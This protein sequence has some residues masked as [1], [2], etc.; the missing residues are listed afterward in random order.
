MV[1]TMAAVPAQA[2]VTRNDQ[3]YL[4][5]LRINEAHRI[6][7][8]G[9]VVVGI[10]DT[11]VNGDQPD[12]VG[13]VL[14]GADAASGFISAAQRDQNGHGTAVATIVAGH[15]HG[16]GGQEGILG[17]SPSAHIL[18]IRADDTRDY[19]AAEA[20]GVSWAADHGAKVICVAFIGNNTAE[21][22]TAVAKARAADALIIA[23]TGNRDSGHNEIGYPA[24]LDGVI[25]VG[26]TTRA[27]ILAGFS[28][29]GQATALT[30]PGTEISTP[31]LGDGYETSEGTSF[32]T[33]IV[34]G[35]AALVRAK[36][37]NLSAAEVAHR[38]E[39]TAD[40]EGPPGRD[41]QYGYGIVN[42]LKALTA[43]VPPLGASPSSTTNNQ[44]A[45]QHDR[46]LIVGTVL[47]AL[48]ALVG[49]VIIVI[50]ALRWRRGQPG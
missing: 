6:V 46:K 33:A 30:A 14:P 44:S 4:N 48:S 25:A 26:A 16:V 29:T 1:A 13:S 21:W 15:G 3:W 12:L 20:N 37:P 18:P 35:V 23:G 34:A 7:T 47:L 28:L 49:A 38:L 2:D 41:D 22:A 9:D 43:D 50:A 24:K 36:F 31:R 8:G 27:G 10:V 40:D 32:S 42:P 45:G 39:A 11:G 19:D 5:T 17:I